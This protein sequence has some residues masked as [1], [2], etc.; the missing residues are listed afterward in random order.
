MIRLRTT[1]FFFASPKTLCSGLLLIVFAALLVNAE[2]GGDSD[3]ARLQMITLDRLAP[4]AVETV[5]IQIDER[6]LQVAT[7]Y[8]SGT[9]PDEAKVR[10]IV[11]GLKGIYVKSSMKKMF[12]PKLISTQFARSF[13]RP[14]GRGSSKCEAD[15]K[16]RISKFMF[17]PG[18][19]ESRGWPSSAL[20]R[21]N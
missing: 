6:L 11:H 18:R 7:K 1:N 15:A 17:S 3:P 10:E 9:R 2:T 12:S 13:A 14:L 4:R 19:K 20:R 16:K 5:D 8:L 21:E